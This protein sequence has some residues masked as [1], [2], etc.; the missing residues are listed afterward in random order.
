[1]QWK[2]IFNRFLYEKITISNLEIVSCTGHQGGHGVEHQEVESLH[3]PHTLKNSSELLG[4]SVT[5]KSRSMEA[6]GGEDLTANGLNS[7]QTYIK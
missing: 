4:E 1:M 6:S 3:V 7:E 5:R 2:N